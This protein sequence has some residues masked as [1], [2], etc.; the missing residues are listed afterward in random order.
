MADSSKQVRVPLTKVLLITAQAAVSAS[1]GAGDPRGRGEA[2]ILTWASR[3]SASHHVVP[4][5]F[6][7]KKPRRSEGGGRKRS[8][9]GRA[10]LHGSKGEQRVHS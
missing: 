4:P 7:D 9:R 5:S 10:M 1:S 3:I 8:V 2:G 6:T